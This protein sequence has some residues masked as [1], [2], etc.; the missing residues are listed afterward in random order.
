MIINPI[1]ISMPKTN[2]QKSPLQE[3]IEFCEKAEPKPFYCDPPEELK[4]HM[5]YS[6]TPQTYSYTIA[7][8]AS[9]TAVSGTITPFTSQ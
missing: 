9:G 1:F 7:S 3:V 8:T 4:F 6:G 2:I 5:D